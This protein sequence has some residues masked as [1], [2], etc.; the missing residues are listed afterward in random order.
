MSPDQGGGSGVEGIRGAAAG[1]GGAAAREGGEGERVLRDGLQIW[2][3]GGFSGGRG[4]DSVVE[5]HAQTPIHR[6]V[7]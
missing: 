6:A 7:A 5:L 4:C 2:R 1:L 3:G